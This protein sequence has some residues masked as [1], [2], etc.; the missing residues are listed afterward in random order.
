GGFVK[1]CCLII[2]L[3]VA[4]CW[5]PTNVE[6]MQILE[7]HL[8]IR[9]SVKPSASN[10]K[11]MMYSEKLEHLAAYWAS[12]CVFRHPSQSDP[13]VYH[14]LGQ[15]LALVAGFEPTLTESV[16]GWNSE[17]KFYNYNNRSCSHVCGH[18]TQVSVPMRRKY[19]TEKPFNVA[20]QLL[21]SL[22]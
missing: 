2:L 9:E 4:A 6:R 13:P 15:N 8:K 7:A 14:G 3:S 5:R 17:A 11:L 21:P 16:C 12:Q 20:L 19:F 18:Y 22:A 1:A 10:M